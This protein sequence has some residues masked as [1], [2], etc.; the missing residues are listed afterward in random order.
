MLAVGRR[1]SGSRWIEGDFIRTSSGASFINIASTTNFRYAVAAGAGRFVT[2]GAGGEI[3]ASGSYSETARPTADL[4]TPGNATVGEETLFQV[5]SSD[6]DG[7]K[8]Y[9]FWDYGD[10]N[11]R[12]GGPTFVHKFTA[13]G[14][15]QIQV[16]VSDGKGELVKDSAYVIVSRP[17]GQ[18][19][20]WINNS[21]PQGWDRAFRADPDSDSISNLL[22]YATNSNPAQRDGQTIDLLENGGDPMAVI[23]LTLRMNDPSLTN[24][25]LVSTDMESW[26][27][28]A[29]I[30]NDTTSAWTTTMPDVI[31]VLRSI[32]KEPGVWL[33]ALNN[34]T[35][36]EAIF[37]S[38]SAS[39]LEN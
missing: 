3:R 5:T 18:F 7:D 22:E 33:F 32:E 13:E 21:L 4:F 38:V 6:P 26:K 19:T 34:N 8:L 12:P 10:G 29:L 24:R 31:T 14:R 2:V 39:Y 35:G 11:L 23:E 28:V 36:E 9:Y 16:I 15:Y 1:Y 27:T 20:N 17:V 37:V 25:I 30:Y